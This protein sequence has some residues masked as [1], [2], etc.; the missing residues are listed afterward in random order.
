MA[1]NRNDQS[2]KRKTIASSDS[3]IPNSMARKRQ[4]TQDNRFIPSQPFDA[5]ASQTGDLDVAAFVAA[6]EYE[7]KALDSA[8][9]SSKK[10]LA[11]RAFQEV[12]RNMRR[13]TASHNVKRV[14]KRLRSLARKQMKEDN[15][16]T[17]TR[18]KR[19][20]SVRMR[21]R[22]E[23]MKRVK[24][25][26]ANARAQA[27][28]R[29]KS[30][31]DARHEKGRNADRTNKDTRAPRITKNALSDPPR[32]TSKFKKRQVKKTW[33]PTHLWHAKRARMTKP[34]EPLWR[35]AIPLRPTEKSYRPTHRAANSRGCIAWDTSYVSTIA[36][37][38]SDA[39]LT[40]MLKS[41]DF[42]ILSEGAEASIWGP[43]GAKWREGLKHASG[44]VHERDQPKRPIAPVTVIWCASCANFKEG[45]TRTTKTFQNGDEQ[46]SETDQQSQAE[47]K[48]ERRP[49]SRLFIRVHPAAFLQLWE[50]LIKDAKIQKP[51][52]L[53]EDLRFQIGSIQVTGPSSTD[54]LLDVLKPVIPQSS[55]T[56]PARIFQSLKGMSNAASAPNDSLLAFEVKDP[57]LRQSEAS[58][59]TSFDSEDESEDSAKLAELLVQWPLDANEQSAQIFSQKHRVHATQ[60]LPSQKAINRR[61]A[62]APRGQTPSAKSSDPKIPAMLLS[63][64][65]RGSPNAQ[66]SWTVLLPWRCVEIV[67]RCLMYFP[68]PSGGQPRFGGLEQERQTAL[69]RGDAW[70]PGDFPGTEAGKSWARSEA[71]ERQKMWE[72]K[73]LGRRINFASMKLRKD[74]Q[75]KGELGS[76][77]DC[78]WT[79]LTSLPSR[80]AAR[81]PAGDSGSCGNNEKSSG[82]ETSLPTLSTVSN[83]TQSTTTTHLVPPLPLA[84]IQN[85]ALG[86]SKPLLLTVKVT[87][88]SRGTPTPCARI[89]SLPNEVDS[90]DLRERWLA[91]DSQQQKHSASSTA[92]ALSQDKLNWRGTVRAHQVYS[93]ELDDLEKMSVHVGNPPGDVFEEFQRKPKSNKRRRAKNKEAEAKTANSDAHNVPLDHHSE[94]GVSALSSTRTALTKSFFAGEAQEAA[95][96]PPL[97]GENDLIGFVTSGAYNLSEGRGVAIGSLWVQKLLAIWEDDKTVLPKSKHAERERHMVIVRNVGEVTGRLA[98]WEQI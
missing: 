60:S 87:F 21:L 81:H 42:G 12:P 95:D 55:T 36:A 32:A 98:V 54:C 45:P 2:L 30:V 84:K 25:K 27:N 48:S 76:P 17:V 51:A 66:G 64:R 44:W 47:K 13:R 41:I 62:L 50:E 18:N 7:I 92:K 86:S 5:A 85:T 71:I 59:H 19:V 52:V 65:S 63:A 61:K 39:S 46:H 33:L 14:P 57:R 75:Q 15:T 96:Y 40:G 83:T 53:L 3:R 34:Q 70:F 16:P 8:I 74:N 35:M 69:E 67:W 88:V 20:K 90:S 78:D 6:R 10:S 82:L 28:T 11:L 37:V 68:L 29:S 56:A 93:N 73:P 58:Q 9:S 38:G 94:D 89:Y 22:I 24:R 97:P 31:T 26:I 43:K 91:L 77:W 4:K 49:K 79:Y 80:R 23:G 72:R 1:E